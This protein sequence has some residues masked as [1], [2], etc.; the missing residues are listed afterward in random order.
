MLAGAETDESGMCKRQWIENATAESRLRSREK[1]SLIAYSHKDLNA[2]G[3]VIRGSLNTGTKKKSILL[4]AEE[5][6]QDH[7]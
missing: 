2:V 5:Q 1:E 6:Q 7:R 4:A 3:G